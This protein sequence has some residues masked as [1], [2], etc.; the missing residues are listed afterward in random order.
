MSI[1]NRQNR[2]FAMHVLRRR[3]FALFL[4][5]RFFAVVAA[6]MQWVAIGWHLYDLTGDPMTLAWAGLA[7]FL[8]IAVLTLPAGD[9]ADRIDRRWLLGAAHLIQACA[10]A[11]LLILVFNKIAVTWPF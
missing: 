9:L 5:G 6:Q 4:G 3:D 11:L 7:S 2:A 8:P 1:A 10:A